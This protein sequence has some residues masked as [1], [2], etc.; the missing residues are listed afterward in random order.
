M[1]I[2]RFN[3]GSGDFYVAEARKQKDGTIRVEVIETSRDLKAL[4]IK[5]EFLS[6]DE[7]EQEDFEIVADIYRHLP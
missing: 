1:K 2:G 4:A 3:K 6:D 7:S 5:Y